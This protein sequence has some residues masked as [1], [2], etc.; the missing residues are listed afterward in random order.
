M[1][2]KTNTALLI[3]VKREKRNVKN[4]LPH[5]FVRRWHILAVANFLLFIF[6][7]TPSS[8]QS[9]PTYESSIEQA[10]TAANEQRYDEAIN[11]FRQALK[12]SPDDIRN[13]L[14][15]ANIAHV[16]EAKGDKMKALDSYDMALGIAPLNVPI[17]KAQADLYMSLGNHNKAA[18]N[19]TKILD[20]DPHNINA[21]LNRA[22]IYQQRHDYEHAKNDYEQLL[23]F[24]PDNYAALLGVAILFQNANKPQEA[25]SRLTTLIDQH[26]DKAELYTIR[27]EIEAEANQPELALIDLDKAITL[28]PTNTNLILTRAYL[29]LH[30]DHKHLAQKDFLRAIELGIPRG[31]LK[32]ELKQCK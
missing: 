32:E 26:P 17:L 3:K 9:L 27:A 30:E 23:T 29:H 19:Y 6:H 4:L 24:D 13:A 8:A 25:I 11:L 20:V 12:I 18:R 21:L 14:T 10:L 2:K 31:Q 5:L 15:Y 22:Y 16:Q 1:K 28:E 7:F